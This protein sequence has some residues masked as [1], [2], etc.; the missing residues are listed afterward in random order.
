MKVLFG[1]M[2]ALPAVGLAQ[3][4]AEPQF[5]INGSVKGLQENSAVFVTDASNPTDTLAESRVKDGQFVLSGHVGEPNLYEVN[6]DG[7]R[8]K[9]P[10]FIAND[11]V[12][13]SGTVQDL[14][15][16]NEVVLV[17]E[18]VIWKYCSSKRFSLSL[19]G[20]YL[21]QCV[22]ETSIVDGGR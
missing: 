9:A 18:P 22:D 4:A 10:L 16:L 3:K 11:K 1:L 20:T 21:L 7:A 14:Q 17:L 15:Q 12:S 13:L 5:T 8:K 19:H 6:F 2:L